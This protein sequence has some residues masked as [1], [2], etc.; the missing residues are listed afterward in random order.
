[1]TRLIIDIHDPKK[2]KEVAELLLKIGG[3]EVE[4]AEASQRRKGTAGIRRAL[5]TREKKF[6]AELRQALKEVNDHMA[7]KSK[8][9]SAR[10]FLNE[11]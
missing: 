9:R 6:V 4:R 1:M 7:G 3:V 10:A 2:E 8:F 5:T 11:L